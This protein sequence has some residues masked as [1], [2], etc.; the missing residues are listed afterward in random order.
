MNMLQRT[1][2]ASECVIDISE[3]SLSFQRSRITRY[4]NTQ[5]KN[6][7]RNQTTAEVGVSRRTSAPRGRRLA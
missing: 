1:T 2:A 5:P 6:G 7:T 4:G 3:L